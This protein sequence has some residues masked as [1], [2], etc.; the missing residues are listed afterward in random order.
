ML[1]FKQ[2]ILESNFSQ[3]PSYL[4]DQIKALI[5]DYVGTS[6]QIEISP[7]N[8][9]KPTDYSL[10]GHIKINHPQNNYAWAAIQV[11]IRFVDVLTKGGG[12]NEKLMLIGISLAEF[13]YIHYMDNRKKSNLFSTLVHETQHAIDIIR[14]KFSDKTK[15][16][17]YKAVD[18]LRKAVLKSEEDAAYRDYIQHP[19]EMH[20]V[21]SE[22]YHTITE[23]YS[24]LK[25][26]SEKLLFLEELKAFIKSGL[27]KY[28]GTGKVLKLPP[29][30]NTNFYKDFLESL[31]P[32]SQPYKQFKL[33]LLNLY[34]NLR[35]VT[36]R[37]SVK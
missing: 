36:P 15:V 10:L 37:F 13:E 18:R 14:N 21:S 8:Y 2:F 16:K 20:P 5:T 26:E 19:V 29:Y 24:N 3:L 25:L 33:R 30:F 31:I 23:Y 9:V 1:P 4:I 22:I 28:V 11:P 35:A 12:F 6:C 32:G 27:D 7:G 17:Y 34:N